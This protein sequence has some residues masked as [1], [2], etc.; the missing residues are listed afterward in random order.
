MGG[1]GSGRP[2]SVATSGRTDSRVLAASIVFGGRGLGPGKPA[3]GSGTWTWEDGFELTLAFETW[4][5]GG[6]IRLRHITRDRAEEE[7]EYTMGLETTAPHF[8]GLRWWFRCP[9]TMRRVEKLFLP[10]GGRR[11]LSRDA[12]RLRFDTKSLDP[13]DR[14]Q[15]R[16]NRL[17]RKLG[18]YDGP[19]D[20]WPPK[21]KGMR[22]H[23][24]DRL[25]DELQRLEC[26]IDD[27]FLRRV[28]GLLELQKLLK[29]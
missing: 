28:G 29:L 14:M 2:K 19:S 17:Q 12:Y 25:I 16:S 3:K 5:D 26:A 1:F 15:R 22:W 13:L 9:S 23:T 18:D 8:G 20:F 24:Y 4:D 7:I 6:H 21:P 10:L 27:E 11:F